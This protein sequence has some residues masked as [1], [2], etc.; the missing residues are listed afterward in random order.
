MASLNEILKKNSKKK[1]F[2]PKIGSK[3]GIFMPKITKIHEKC[4]KKERKWV[5]SQFLEGVRSSYSARIRKW[6]V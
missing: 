5:V 6:Q 3:I 4:K 1:F 2:L